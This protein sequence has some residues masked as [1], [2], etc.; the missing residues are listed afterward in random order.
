MTD[1]DFLHRHLRRL[2]VDKVVRD[3]PVA[4]LQVSMLRDTLS[5]LRSALDDEG[6][7]PN[8]ARR[9]I[10][11]VIYGG[12]PM[13]WVSEQRIQERAEWADLLADRPLE[14]PHG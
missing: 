5:L 9:V 4:H 2:G 12:T 8:V 6:V 7:A 11:R 1:S 13:P 3:D 14:F 10:E